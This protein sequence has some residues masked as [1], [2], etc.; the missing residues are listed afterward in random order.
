VQAASLKG[1]SSPKGRKVKAK[2]WELIFLIKYSSHQWLFTLNSTYVKNRFF[3]GLKSARCAF[4]LI[5]IKCTCPL[6]SNSCLCYIRSVGE[7]ISSAGWQIAPALN[8][9]VRRGLSVLLATRLV[10]RYTRARKGL[11]WFGPPECNTLL[12]CVM[13]CLGACMNL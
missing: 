3:I 6:E 7:E 1:Y 2:V 5:L 13:Y 12:H 10:D 8:L 4:N 11:E 9:K